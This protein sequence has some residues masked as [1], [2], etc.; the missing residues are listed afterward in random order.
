MPDS[1]FVEVEGARI[2]YEADGHGHPLL[3]IHGGLG[4]L[5]MWQDQ[6][7]ALAERHRVIRYD[8]RG[9]GRTEV[10]PVG[11]MDHEDAAAV[12]DHFGAT[13]AYVVGQS[14]G[15]AIALDFVLA[16]PERADAL[17]SVSGGIHG[18]E[19]DLPAGTEPPGDEMERLW[20]D[21]DWAALA[22]LEARVWVDGWGQPPSRVE[23]A[24]RQQ[25]L[26]WIE[27][28]YAQEKDEGTPRQL[29]PPAAERLHELKLPTLAM[30]GD[31]DEAGCVAA[32]RHLTASVEGARLEEFPG[33]AHMIQL[34]EPERFNRLVL[35]FLARVESRV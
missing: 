31:V 20:E 19:A 33:V 16:Y 27:Q 22:E 5:R 32:M 26:G 25:V 2:Y 14:R 29:D 15:G 6:I 11:Y 30:I 9:W 12:L 13:S 4:D 8:T 28:N 17:I 7:P 21:K 24:I 3:L 1:G 10:E 35:A 23:P 34:E 18:Y